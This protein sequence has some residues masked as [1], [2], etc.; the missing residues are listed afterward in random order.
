MVLPE[1]AYR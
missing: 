1:C